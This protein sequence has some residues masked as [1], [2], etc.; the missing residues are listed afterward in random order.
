MVI[1]IELPEKIDKR[2]GGLGSYLR[3]FLEE[4]IYRIDMRELEN[5]HWSMAKIRIAEYLDSN[6]DLI[7]ISKNKKIIECELSPGLSAQIITLLEMAKYLIEKD[8]VDEEVITCFEEFSKFTF[9]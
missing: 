9:L 4:V 5:I 1:R 6:N 3:L 8:K 2:I 7:K